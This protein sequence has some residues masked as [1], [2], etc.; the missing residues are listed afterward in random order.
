MRK[1][2]A[3]VSALILVVFTLIVGLTACRKEACGEVVKAEECLLVIRVTDAPD[4]AT[5]KDVMDKM[6][7]EGKIAFEES[8]GMILSVDGKVPTGNEFWGLYTSATDYANGGW[9]SAEVDDVTY[10]SAILGYAS[11]P[12][13]EGELYIWKIS[14][15]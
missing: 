5:L 15:W 3:K 14:T 1:F 6:Q 2:L 7:A 10:D 12:A 8:G 11:L 13:I 4:G 9:G